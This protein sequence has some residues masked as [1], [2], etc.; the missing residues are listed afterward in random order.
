MNP[1]IDETIERVEQLYV[2]ITGKR[3]PQVN[4]SSAPIPPETDP[5]RH[6]EE[7]L[8]KL[9]EAVQQ[10]APTVM[11]NAAA[12]AGPTPAWIPR[13]TAWQ[14]GGALELA[15]E[16]P[17]VTREQLEIRLDDRTLTIQGQRVAP[18]RT[19]ESAAV[20]VC[21]MPSGT[22]TRSFTLGASVQPEQITA[23]LESG[24]L[25]ISVAR[26]T[27]AEPSQIPIKV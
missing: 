24:V 4:G 18:W 20:E 13:V 27:R 12:F 17:G 6:V 3:P 23:R 14:E 1:S 11:P 8:R 21:E 9:M 16:V 10:V 26:V 5:A 19:S 2:A 25:R 15:I 22:F 7:Q